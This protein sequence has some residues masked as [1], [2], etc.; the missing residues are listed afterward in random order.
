M[1][2][3]PIRVAGDYWNNPSEVKEQLSQVPQGETIV[4]DMHTEGA[5]LTAL[6]IMPML[7]QYCEQ[8]QRDIRDIWIANW[9]NTVEMAPMQRTNL[10]R[11]SHF[12][13][14]SENYKPDDGI[15]STHKHRIGYFIG[16]RSIAREVIMWEL[17]KQR[18]DQCLFSLM[19]QHLPSPDSNQLDKWL[20]VE[21][22]AEFQAFWNTPPITSLDNLA[23]RDQY[24]PN[25]RTNRSILDFYHEFDIEL[26]AE[27]YCL[28]DTFFPTEKTI[29]PISAGKSVVVYGPKHYLKRMRELGFQTYN[30]IWDESYDNFEGP[31]RWRAMKKTLEHIFSLDTMTLDVAVAGINAHNLSVLNNLIERYRPQ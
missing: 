10:P 19:R 15:G 9:P 28:G 13:W 11:I 21:Q 8:T 16:R 2:T 26:V 29:R 20:P 3:I 18:K 5:S 14:M 22:Q 7:E 12:F 17:Y 23:I 25:P 31:E 4:L 30:N 24:V 1:I 6:G 27:T